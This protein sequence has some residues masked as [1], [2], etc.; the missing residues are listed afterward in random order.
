MNVRTNFYI[1]NINYV[2]NGPAA[3]E[4]IDQS[5]FDKNNITIEYK[6]YT[7]VVL[8]LFCS[9]LRENSAKLYESIGFEKS[10]EKSPVIVSGNVVWSLVPVTQSTR[11]LPS[12]SCKE[13]I[14]VLCYKFAFCPRTHTVLFAEIV[15]I[16]FV[17]FEFRLQIG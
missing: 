13:R 9:Y 15:N 10:P 12:T 6:D 7:Q 4:F 16:P 17:V 8:D 14:A 3:K 11:S 1:R 2:I 5:L